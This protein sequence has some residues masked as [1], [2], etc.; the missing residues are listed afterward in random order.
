MARPKRS[1][2]DEAIS[3]SSCFLG[4]SSSQNSLLFLCSCQEGSDPSHGSQ[5]RAGIGRQAFVESLTGYAYSLS[6][7]DIAQGSFLGVKP[8]PV[9]QLTLFFIEITLHACRLKQQLYVAEYE[10]I[11]Q[12]AQPLRGILNLSWD[13]RPRLLSALSRGHFYSLSPVWRLKLEVEGDRV[14]NPH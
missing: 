12:N 4:R 9:K 8:E 14:A 13:Q 1:L 11:Q 2:A 5:I 7:L 3:T 10:E 6:Q